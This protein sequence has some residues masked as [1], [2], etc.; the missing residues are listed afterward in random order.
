M[1]RQRF[2]EVVQRERPGSEAHASALL[3]IGELEFAVGNVAAAR[4]AAQEARDTFERLNTAPLGLA[5]CNLA[6]YAM[7]GGDLE[8]AR[9]LLREAL[10][11][12]RQTGARWTLTALEHHALLAGLLGDTE[13]AATLAGFTSARYAADDTRQTTERIGYERLMKLL[14]DRYAEAEL[15]QR[16]DAGARLS[17]EQA[18]ECA[19]AIDSSKPSGPVAQAAEK[20]A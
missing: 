17:E 11:I 7:A 15:T 18:L 5:T 16:L 2:T 6:A 19:A 4:A 8:S 3:N 10:V 13:R 9:E 20:R 1:A 14:R 12:M